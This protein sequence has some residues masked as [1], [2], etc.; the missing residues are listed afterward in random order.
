[1]AYLKR[2]KLGR[3]REDLL[4]ASPDTE[5]VGDIA[6]IWGFY[7][8]SSFAR[9]YRRVFGELPSESLKRGD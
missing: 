9:D 7:H 4:A 1:M 6:A 8:L 2:V 5:F 3:C